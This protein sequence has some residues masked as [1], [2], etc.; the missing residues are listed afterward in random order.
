MATSTK[1]RIEPPVSPPADSHAPSPASI[2][3]KPTSSTP[4]AGQASATEGGP[5]ATLDLWQEAYDKVDAKIRKWVD[6]NPT[7][8]NTKDPIS[9]LVELIRSREKA[10]ENKALKL[11]VGDREILWR[12]YANRVVSV[13]TAMGDITINFAPAPATTVWSAVKVLLNT[14]VSERKDFVAIM[15]CTD[16][17]LCL[18]RRGRVYE[19]VYIGNSPRPSY[20]EDLKKTLVDIYVSCLDFLAFIYEEMRHNNLSRFVDA[21]LDPGH[22]EKRVLELKEFEQKL[23]SAVRPCEAKASNEHRNK[24]WGLLQSLEGPLKRVDKNVAAVLKKLED[25]DRKKAMKYISTIPVGYHHNE[26]REKRTKGTC[27]WLVTHDRFLEWEDSPCSSVC[28]LQGN[29]GTGKSFLSSKVIDRYW[30]RGKPASQMRSG[31]DEGFAFF[32]CN[33][34]DPTRHSTKSILRSY[35]RQLGEISHH[36]ESVHEAMNNLYRKKEQIQSDITVEDCETA[37][38]EMI[39]TYPR[40]VLILDALDECRKDVRRQLGELF[41]RLVKN[42][43]RLLKIFIT[44][45]QEPGHD[46][47]EYLKS[48]HGSRAMISISTSDNQGDIRKFIDAE[49]ANFPKTWDNK[50]ITRTLV[51]KSDGMFR[52]TSLQCDRLKGC[53]TYG[54]V[55]KRLKALPTTLKEAYDE[56]YDEFES[57]SVALV[58]LQ[59]VVRWVTHA[60]KPF[61]SCTLL[62]AI[63]VESKKTDGENFLNDSDLTEE[64]LENVCRHLVVKDRDLGVWKFPHASVAEYFEAK[65]ES[66]VQDAQAELTVVLINCITDCCSDFFS[67]VALDDLGESYPI[68]R[69]KDW[70]TAP[71]AAP[72]QTSDP[73]HPLQTY[74]QQNWLSHIQKISSKDS[75]AAD[76]AEALKRFLGEKGPRKSSKEYRVFCDHIMPEQWHYYREMLYKIKPVTNWAFGV[77]AFGLHRVLA[78]WWDKDIDPTRLV[79]DEGSDLLIIAAY[80]GHIDLC[81]DLI[82]RGCELNPGE[83]R[84]HNCALHASI[85]EGNFEITKL[86]LASGASPDRVFKKQSLLCLSIERGIEYFQL[87]FDNKANPDI[88]CSDSPKSRRPCDFGCALS[89]AAHDGNLHILQALIDMGADVNPQDLHDKYGSPLAAAVYNGH[90]FCARLLLKHGADAKARLKYG[91]Y[92]DPLTAAVFNGHLACAQLLL[93]HGADAKAQ[94][95]D[96]HYGSPLIAAAYGGNIDCARLLIGRGV[97]ANMNLAL[98]FYGSPLAAAVWKGRFECTRFLTENGADVNMCQRGGL[99]DSVLAAAVLGPGVSLRMIKYLIEEKMADPAQ[100]ALIRPLSESRGWS[101]IRRHSVQGSGARNVAAYLVRELQIK[102]NMLVTAG[103]IEDNML[104]AVL[105]IARAPDGKFEE[106]CDRG[107][108]F[109]DEYE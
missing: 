96:G 71:G 7:P 43:N 102:A 86:L 53:Y 60:R 80:F 59:R 75:K 72:D 101:S 1:P 10:L 74:C 51:E 49:V 35:I 21:L 28:W 90:L 100:L 34:S 70:S 69:I 105:D 85:S 25:E 32:Y 54:D 78:G 17:V 92:G 22:G 57:D 56:I 31:H 50:T 63:R 68:S 77:V 65:K 103:V 109:G 20:Q 73:R 88:R 83:E 95:T 26:K 44:S 23:E 9:E 61:D 108:F 67:F 33:S 94:L 5:T 91:Q 13:V 15:G 30:I 47:G 2:E 89:R 58:I 18:V 42:S 16:I 87:M 6:G 107:I 84:L 3:D 4:T 45:R 55:E 97:D 27:E 41:K 40:T 36:P 98:G 52:W 79:N 11:K 48:L 99:Y 106:L 8:A 12:D 64:G 29:I 38:I 93:E 76:V 104:A 82:S 14:H 81:K 19:K 39:N 24:H 46:I 66:W 37:L 62:A